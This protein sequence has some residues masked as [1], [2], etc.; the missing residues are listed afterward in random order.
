M[1]PLIIRRSFAVALIALGL[2]SSTGCSSPA[3]I[4]YIPEGGAYT[5]DDLPGVLDAADSADL[6]G[7]PADEVDETR[8]EVLADLRTHGEDAAALADALT[9]QFPVDVNS[10]PIEVRLA[11]YEGAPAWVIVESWGAA[12]RPLST[13]RLWVFSAESLELITALSEQ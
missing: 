10:V 13:R 5:A 3:R 12:G 2:M 6:A 4:S 9:T 1:T 8:Q 11:T 7:L